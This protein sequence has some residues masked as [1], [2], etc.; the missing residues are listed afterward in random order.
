MRA[1]QL[2]ASGG[3]A[4]GSLSDPT[5]P[6]FHALN[7]ELKQFYDFLKEQHT[8]RLTAEAAA[9]AP[10]AGAG[11]SASAAGAAPAPWKSRYGTPLSGGTDACY[12]LWPSKAGKWPILFFCSEEVLAADTDAT[13]GNER[14]HNPGQRIANKLRSSLKPR[15]I[16][17][18][19]L[20]SVHLRKMA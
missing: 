5:M 10:A 14:S 3:A 15:T 13:V 6:L 1:E 2:D 4:I 19:T 8:E 12:E 7:E 16:E 17:Q 9:R 11:V 18:L 20:A